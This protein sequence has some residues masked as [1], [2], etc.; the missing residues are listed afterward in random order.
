MPD[1]APSAGRAGTFLRLAAVG[2]TL[3]VAASLFRSVQ[4]WRAWSSNIPEEMDGLHATLQ[5]AAVG[6]GLAAVLVFAGILGA[7]LALRG[8]MRVAAIGAS[9]YALQI[10]IWTIQ[11]FLDASELAALMRAIPWP[12]YVVAHVVMDVGLIMTLIR[13]QG[14]VSGLARVA[15]GASVCVWGW[16]IL[17]R[18]GV[19][20]EELEGPLVLIVSSAIGAVHG[21]VFVAVLFALSRGGVVDPGAVGRPTE[22]S[23]GLRLFSTGLKLRIMCLVGVVALSVLLTVSRSAGGLKGVLYGGTMISMGAGLLMVAGLGRYALAR[24]NDLGSI[25]A[26]V[27][28]AVG[29]LLELWTLSLLSDLFGGRFGAALSAQSSLGWAQGLGQGLGLV[30]MLALLTSLRQVA[31]FGDDLALAGRAGGLMGLVVGVAGLATAV[32]VL[33]NARSVPVALGLVLG[34]SALSAAIVMIVRLLSLIRDVA[35]HLEADSA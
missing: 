15:I 35:R 11:P 3:S 29:V 6:E 10:L 22:A 2:L 7:A 1:S 14:A 30:A 18:L 9:V 33:A 23:S 13:R 27:L 8:P 16:A 17:G 21:G 19:Q 34:L 20:F 12:V 32:R 31:R 4:W 28:M 26:T 24:Q 25:I 5:A